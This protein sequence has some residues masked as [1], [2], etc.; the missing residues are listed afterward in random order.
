MTEEAF[1]TP[2]ATSEFFRISCHQKTSLR[3]KILGEVL[4]QLLHPD[5]KLLFQTYK[6]EI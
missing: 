6:C 3:E 1:P 2:N 5:K 4:S